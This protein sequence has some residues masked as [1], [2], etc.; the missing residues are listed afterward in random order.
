MKGERRRARGRQSGVIE[1]V[2]DEVGGGAAGEM[3][4][5]SVGILGR[6]TRQL[7]WMTSNASHSSSLSLFFFFFLFV[8]LFLLDLRRSVFLLQ[9]C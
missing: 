3:R 1:K 8:V 9:S 7:M 2:K 6:D 5:P 4:R